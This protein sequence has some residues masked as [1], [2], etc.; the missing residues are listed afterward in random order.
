MNE[1]IRLECPNCGQSLSIVGHQTEKHY[2]IANKDFMNN[3]VLGLFQGATKRIVI[4]K[5]FL[6]ESGQYPSSNIP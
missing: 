2:S 4:Q 6:K 1:I 5:E 3:F